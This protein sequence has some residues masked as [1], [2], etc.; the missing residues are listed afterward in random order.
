MQVSRAYT[1]LDKY[2]KDNHAASQAVERSTI[3]HPA[4]LVRRC[5]HYSL[6]TVASP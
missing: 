3:Q 1:A 6:A 5:H 2:L 4:D